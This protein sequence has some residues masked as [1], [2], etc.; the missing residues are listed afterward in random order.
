MQ[1]DLSNEDCQ[2]NKCKESA[3]MRIAKVIYARSGNEDCQGNKSEESAEMSIA[4]VINARRVLIFSRSPSSRRT[5]LCCGLSSGRPMIITM[6]CCNLQIQVAI[7]NVMLWVVIWSPYAIV[8]MI[9]CLG[10]QALYK[11]T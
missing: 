4:K 11:K 9:G 5:L 2:G 1:G 6:I 8:N 10:N 7:T 3:E